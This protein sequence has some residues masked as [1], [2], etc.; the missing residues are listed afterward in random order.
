MKKTAKLILVLTPLF[1]SSQ[2]RQPIVN[3]SYQLYQI[4]GK[5]LIQSTNVVRFHKCSKALEPGYY[6]VVQENLEGNKAYKLIQ[7]QD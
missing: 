4:T 1:V 3:H 5:L 6:L 2:Q 7:V